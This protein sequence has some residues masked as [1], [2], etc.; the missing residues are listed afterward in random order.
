MVSLKKESGENRQM[1]ISIFCS[2]APGVQEGFKGENGSV[3]HVL[4]LPPSPHPLASLLGQ[5]GMWRGGGDGGI[6]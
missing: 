6:S 2:G 4:S 1:C 3:A 5:R